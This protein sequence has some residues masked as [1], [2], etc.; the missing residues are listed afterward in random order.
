MEEI[1]CSAK[2]APPLSPIQKRMYI[3]NN[4]L[5]FR[6]SLK[7]GLIKAKKIPNK[8]QTRGM[9]NIFLMIKSE[10]FIGLSELC[11]FDLDYFIHV[12]Y[13]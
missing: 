8:K 4:L 9:L 12:N 13:L 1:A 2:G 6:G 5:S 10:K 11:F 7:P 3:V